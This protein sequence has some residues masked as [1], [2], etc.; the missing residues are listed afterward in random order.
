[1]GRTI[2]GMPLWRSASDP[3]SGNPYWYDTA[4]SSEVTWERPEH[5]NAG[6]PQAAPPPAVATPGA[7][8]A[9][10]VGAYGYNP[11]QQPAPMQQASGQPYQ[12]QTLGG[13]QQH[14]WVG[15]RFDC[16]NDVG[17]ACLSLFCGCVVFGQTME[18]AKLNGCFPAAFTIMAAYI[19]PYMFIQIIGAVAMVDLGGL[20]WLLGST[21]AAYYAMEQRKKLRDKYGLHWEG[22]T[23]EFCW[24]WCCFC[25][26]NHQQHKTIMTNVNPSDGQWIEQQQPQPGMQPHQVQMQ[27]QH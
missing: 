4:D 3:S 6:A 19:G 26:T 18:R 25:C 7:G 14:P 23:Q 17:L 27:P 1:M 20:A 24:L 13:I 9:A 16:G 11:H 21:C 8:G 10:P 22:D 15:G 2:Q 5:F 12:P